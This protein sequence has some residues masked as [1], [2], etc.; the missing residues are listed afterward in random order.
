MILFDYLHLVEWVAVGVLVLS[1][2]G[3]LLLWMRGRWSREGDLLERADAE[4]E[5]RRL[6]DG[7]WQALRRG[8]IEQ[9]E[10]LLR[11]AVRIYEEQGDPALI[12]YARYRL[13][14]FY[15]MR[16]ELD[17]SIRALKPVVERKSSL[18][19]PYRFLSGLYERV[20]RFDRAER[21][22]RVARRYCGNLSGLSLWLRLL[23]DE[24][25][26]RSVKTNSGK[27][28]AFS[29]AE[30]SGVERK[31]VAALMELGF[32]GLPLLANAKAEDLT[33]IPHLGETTATRI[34]EE[35]RKR[36]EKLR[37]KKENNHV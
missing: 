22:L 7:G 10:R 37:R 25:Y 33:V 9:A 12:G 1:L 17:R 31:T 32:A 29:L 14:I 34:I 8:D 27:Y 4:L 21:A 18:P 28:L 13:A 26:R 6:L 5:G 11:G 20:G 3:V 35:A 23:Q 15:K 36:I 24:D 16:G 19:Q 30:L 2:L